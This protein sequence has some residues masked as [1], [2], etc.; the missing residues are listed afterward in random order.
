MLKC[1]CTTPCTF[2]GYES[3]YK[4][5]KACDGSDKKLLEDWMSREKEKRLYIQQRNEVNSWIENNPITKK[6]MDNVSKMV[7]DHHRDMIYYYKRDVEETIKL[8]NRLHS[9]END[10]HY[11]MTFEEVRNR[12]KDPKTAIE[13][14]IFNDPATIVMWADHTKTV[15]KCQDGDIFDPEKGLAMAI[16]K[17]FFGNKGNYCDVFTKWLPK[18][19]ETTEEEETTIDISMIANAAERNLRISCNMAKA[20]NKVC[21]RCEECKYENVLGYKWPCVKCTSGSKWKPAKGE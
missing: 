9:E 13:K 1:Y 21:G 2:Y 10:M 17:K 18:E 8:Y 16:A 14:V 12:I 5:C 3:N 15:V 4:F 11:R 7:A 19:E 6:V 20:V